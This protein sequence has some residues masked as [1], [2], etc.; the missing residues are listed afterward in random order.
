MIFTTKI[1][2]LHMSRSN[3]E[4]IDFK[5]H[6][7]KNIRL[8]FAK[9][10]LKK[11]QAESNLIVENLEK[12]PDWIAAK[13]IMAFAPLSDEP[14]ILPA[15]QNALITK[16][17][18]LPVINNE[19]LVVKRVS[20]I[21]DLIKETRYGILEPSGDQFE[22]LKAIDLILVP[23]VAFTKNGKRLGRGKGYYDKFLRKINCTFIGVGF[24]FQIID[25]IPLESHDIILNEIIHPGGN[26]K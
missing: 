17:V 26:Y 1:Q 19:D 13:T 18:L 20:S 5:R 8:L 24:T 12:H 21:P 10:P 3:I 6:I 14:N 9:T 25:D 16:T 7:R 4:I 22:T 23:G 11:L 15:L 2:Y